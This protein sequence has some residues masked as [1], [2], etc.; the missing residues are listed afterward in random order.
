MKK[1]ICI[2]FFAAFFLLY[3]FGLYLLWKP[4]E[5]NNVEPEPIVAEAETEYSVEE[6]MSIQTTYAYW[7][8][9]KDGR[10]IVCS[11]DGKEILFETNIE[12]KHLEKELQERIRGGIGFSDEG[13]LYDF[14]ESY[15]S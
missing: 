4:Q 3:V 12:L 1:T 13:E 8:M 2:C 6:S 15:S 14:L 7:I 9:E 5:E 11:A 10:V